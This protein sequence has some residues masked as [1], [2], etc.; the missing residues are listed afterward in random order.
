MRRGTQSGLPV[1]LPRGLPRG[2][3]VREADN[4]R[5]V[6]VGDVALVPGG[7]QHAEGVAVVGAKV[8]G[9][10]VLRPLLQQPERAGA[11]DH[12]GVEGVVGDAVVVHRSLPDNGV[13]LELD[14]IGRCTTE[15]L[16][17]PQRDSLSDGVEEDLI[18]VG[19]V[20]VDAVPVG[21]H[22]GV[23]PHRGA[24]AAVVEVDARH[25]DIVGGVGGGVPH[26][27][28]QEVV[29]DEVAVGG[30][31]VRVDGAAVVQDGHRVADRVAEDR[32]THAREADGSVAN[33][34]KGVIRDGAS[35]QVDAQANVAVVS[36]DG[37]PRHQADGAEVVVDYTEVGPTAHH[38][39]PQD[40]GLRQSGAEAHVQ[41]T[42]S[43]KSEFWTMRLVAP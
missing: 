12:V 33:V 27:P 3:V 17:R 31:A 42:Y 37:D 2:Q 4:V 34:C 30:D 5:G 40:A 20:D 22:H 6:D 16:A 29:G 36:G 13:L 14:G 28:V 26:D 15:G 10:G 8:A 25:R 9:A 39:S 7:V 19:V 38:A 23:V 21:V 41:D 35:S 18:V 1:L 43:L 32:G 11:G 24:E